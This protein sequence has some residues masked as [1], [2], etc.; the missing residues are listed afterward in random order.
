MKRYIYSLL[1]IITLVSSCK[2]VDDGGFSQFDEAPLFGMIYDLESSPVTGVVVVLDDEKSS[3]TDINGRVLFG[4]VSRGEHSV[5]ITKEGFEETRM[6]LNFSNRDQVLYSTLIPLQNILDNLESYLQF[7]KMT[8]A[9]SF[10]ERA[11]KIN[12]DDIRYMYLNVVYLTEVKEYSEAFREIVLL[13]KTYPDDT[14]LT[15]THA[16]ILFYGLNK[17]AEALE[18]LQ[19]YKLLIR[20]EEFESLMEKMDSEII[21]GESND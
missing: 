7:G 17:K 4:A 5:V 3:Q 13:R 10:L 19:N 9:K 8:E 1:L 15:M 16:K 18:L 12:S 14:Y 21:T 20:N 6:V 2:S 11:E